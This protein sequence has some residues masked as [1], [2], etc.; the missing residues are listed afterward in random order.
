MDRTP[1]SLSR[2]RCAI[3]CCPG[4]QIR[5]FVVSAAPVV[6]MVRAVGVPPGG[7][8]FGMRRRIPQPHP[9][10]GTPFRVPRKR[11]PG[12]QKEKPG[13]SWPGRRMLSSE[14]AFS[15]HVLVAAAVRRPVFPARAGRPMGGPSLFPD[16]TC[17][18]A[19]PAHQ[20][21]VTICSRPAPSPR[22]L[23]LPLAPFAS[24]RKRARAPGSR[25]SCVV[26]RGPSAS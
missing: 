17:P 21:K 14:H 8:G 22:A 2:R 7:C 5:R 13:T 1:L 18:W 9:S 20:G 16:V 11:S 25:R 15:V 3:G 12:D 24:R 26:H 23:G 10:G 19:T 4:R 6:L